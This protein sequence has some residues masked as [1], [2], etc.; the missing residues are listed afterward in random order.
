MEMSLKSNKEKATE[1]FSLVGD[2]N[3]KIKN[4]IK[5]MMDVS[6]VSSCLKSQKHPGVL[7]MAYF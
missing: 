2:R 6:R 4:R 3:E 1:A 7:P 5:Q